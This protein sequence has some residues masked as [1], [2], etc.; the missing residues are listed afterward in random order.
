MYEPTK[1]II[2]VTNNTTHYRVRGQLGTIITVSCNIGILFAFIAGNFLSYMT[3]TYCLIAI[4]VLFLVVFV[5]FPE[6]PT[7]LMMIDEPKVRLYI[8]M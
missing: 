7:Y 5:G 1:Q 8:Y 4:P 3:F 2:V 6:S